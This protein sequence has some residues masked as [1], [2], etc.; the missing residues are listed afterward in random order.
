MTPCPSTRP[1]H[2]ET[3]LRFAPTRAARDG[4][5]SP[6]RGV[7]VRTAGSRPTARDSAFPRRRY[8][9]APA[10]AGRS[11]HHYHP[12]YP[13]RGAARARGGSDP[14]GLGRQPGFSGKRIGRS[15]GRAHRSAERRADAA[16]L[17]GPG[18]GGSLRRL[19]GVGGLP[20]DPMRVERKCTASGESRPLM[21]IFGI[22][23]RRQYRRQQVPGTQ[24]QHCRLGP[25][26]KETKRCA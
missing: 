23:V 22:P 7:V 14:A 1:M 5:P 9:P 17:L 24:P 20:R 8:S 6:R 12:R 4:T 26:A 19:V 11:L 21:S 2:G 16:G 15:A 13:K 3:W 10:Y 25:V 18:S